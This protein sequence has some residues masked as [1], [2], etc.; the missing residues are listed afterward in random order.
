AFLRRRGPAALRRQRTAGRRALAARLDTRAMGHV[1]GHAALAAGP[2]PAVFADLAARQ[3]GGDSAGEPDR[4]A[5]GA[6]GRRARPGVLAA[7]RACPDDGADVA[8]A[9]HGR[10]ALQRLAAGGGAVRADRAGPARRPVAALAAR[11]PSALAGPAA[12]ADAAAM[13]AA[14]PGP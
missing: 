3:R 6:A 10:S 8:D 2:V 9:E 1:R 7:P 14:A 4:H 12:P 5:T 11:L 13:D